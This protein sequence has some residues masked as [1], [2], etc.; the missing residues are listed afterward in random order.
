[1]RH[2]A[3]QPSGGIPRDEESAFRAR[4]QALIDNWQVVIRNAKNEEA[5]KTEKGAINVPHL[6]LIFQ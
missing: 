3:S 5:N 6:R 1:M 4:A 2:I